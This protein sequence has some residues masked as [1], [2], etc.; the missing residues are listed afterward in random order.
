MLQI[1]LADL[2]RFGISLGVIIAIGQAKSAGERVGFHTFGVIEIRFGIKTE[3][4]ICVDSGPMFRCDVGGDVSPGLQRRNA[5]HLR[6]NGLGTSFLDRRYP[7]QPRD[8]SKPTNMGIPI[9]AGVSQLQRHDQIGEFSVRATKP[10]R[11]LGASW[12]ALLYN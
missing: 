9:T 3:K 11:H 7:I 8:L 2:N 10:C 12:A 1:A 4:N 5:G 6:R